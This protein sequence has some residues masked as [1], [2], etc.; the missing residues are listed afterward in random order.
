MGRGSLKYRSTSHTDRSSHKSTTFPHM[1]Q[2]YHIVE[3]MCKLGTVQQA[4]AGWGKAQFDSDDEFDDYYSDTDDDDVMPDLEDEEQDVPPQSR[5]RTSSIYKPLKPL[6]IRLFRMDSAADA[7]DNKAEIVLSL[8][9]YL[10]SEAPPFSALSYCWGDPATTASL[11]VNGNVLPITNNLNTALRRLRT[12]QERDHI[13]FWWVDAICIHQQNLRERAE[14]VMLM[15]EIFRVASSVVVWLGEPQSAGN[16]F[17]HDVKAIH[18]YIDDH[19]SGQSTL[20]PP[21]VKIVE[22]HLPGVYDLVGNAYFTRLWMVQETMAARRAVFYSGGTAEN[23]DTV[24]RVCKW[25]SATGLI[26]SDSRQ[27]SRNL[28]RAQSLLLR[29]ES[30]TLL[31]LLCRF[32]GLKC[33]DDRDKVFALLTTSRENRDTYDV[34][35][36]YTQSVVEVYTGICRFVLQR[37]RQ[38]HIL[39]C[40]QNATESPD[41]PSW[42]PDWRRTWSHMALDV[43]FGA[44]QVHHVFRASQEMRAM[45]TPSTDPRILTVK[46]VPIDTVR[47]TDKPEKD[48]ILAASA[49][50]FQDFADK[51]L[52]RL[53]IEDPE[54]PYLLT[55]ESYRE[56]LFRTLSADFVMKAPSS[57]PSSPASTTAPSPLPIILPVE[58]ALGHQDEL[59]FKPRTVRR[60]H[61]TP[62]NHTYMSPW[63]DSLEAYHPTAVEAYSIPGAPVCTR[64]IYKHIQNLMI[65]RLLF[66][67]E[68]GHLGLGPEDARLGDQVVVLPGA[69]VPFVLR[70]VGGGAGEYRVVGEC[71]VHGFMDGV[72][73][74]GKEA[75]AWREYVLC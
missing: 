62:L 10:I 73:V 17:L 5:Q 41:L 58:D 74:E 2:V 13:Q 45:V 54:T 68:T 26:W 9:N 57:S 63:T 18:S 25:V 31:H 39:S 1:P 40:V 49:V 34:L 44:E 33:S 8:D 24:T 51:L 56:A 21:D 14:Q 53:G 23:W 16:N 37:S 42:T 11:Q 4:V 12:V 61:S 52:H 6:E 15:R 36:D 32:R 60:W 35:P 72:A 47:T 27:S 66:V 38:L 7:T 22:P 75:A 46:G 67:T 70:S 29:H 3:Q 59:V 55:G 20:P 64:S 69:D 50:S 28:T 43:Y 30:P 48:A 65:G 19:E 71:Y